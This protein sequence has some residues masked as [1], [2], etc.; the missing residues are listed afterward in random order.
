[1]LRR[2]RHI[3]IRR[4]V[5][6]NLEEALKL[7]KSVERL[8]QGSFEVLETE[9]NNLR[10]PD[11]LAALA[12]YLTYYLNGK[13]LKDTEMRNKILGELY[14]ALTV[15]S[16][17]SNSRNL[18][19]LR[20]HIGKLMIKADWDGKEVP[21]ELQHIIAN[22]INA[23]GYSFSDI[24]KLI[25]KIHEEYTTLQ[26]RKIPVVTD[27]EVV[28]S[29]VFEAKDH[30]LEW[31]PAV[32]LRTSAEELKR[33]KIRRLRQAGERIKKLLAKNPV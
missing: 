24:E 17:L 29:A 6:R 1:M 2:I 28:H 16:D 13:N 15:L 27:K 23:S 31:Q 10:A 32:Y 20:D 25:R 18:E 21:H 8:R 12:A 26:I 30:W 33:E 4:R 7:L 11:H 3:L 5:R 19:K 9:A 22:L 14:S